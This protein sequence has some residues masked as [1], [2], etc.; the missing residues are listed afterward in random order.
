MKTVQSHQE[1]NFAK[2]SIFEEFSNI[3]LTVCSMKLETRHLF[4]VVFKLTYSKKF[5]PQHKIKY[6]GTT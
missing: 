2:C 1:N 6:M 5:G 3:G 4:E